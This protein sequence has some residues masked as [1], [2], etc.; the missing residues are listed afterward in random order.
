MANGLKGFTEKHGELW[1]FIKFS[2]AGVSSFVV[3]YLV[4]L[5]FHYV[6]F[7]SLQGKTIE[8]PVFEFLGIASQMDAAYAYLIAATVGYIVAYLMNRKVTFNASGHLT[9]SVVI[10]VVMVVVTIFVTAW[11]KGWLLGIAAANGHV[12]ADGSVTW[13]WDTVIFI[14]TVTLPFVWTYPLQRFV[15]N[16][17][18]KKTAEE[19]A[20]AEAVAE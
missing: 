1:K 19:A 11:L 12:N 8:N 9:R 4:D 15:I 7:A 5:L 6:V 2:F 20:A 16:P 17:P 18:A 14:F 13:F 10:Y 3:Q